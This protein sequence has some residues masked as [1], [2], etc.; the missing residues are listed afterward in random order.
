MNWRRLDAEPPEDSLVSPN[1]THIL[2]IRLTITTRRPYPVHDAEIV[3]AAQQEP[4]S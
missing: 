1:D 4:M 3:P 2:G